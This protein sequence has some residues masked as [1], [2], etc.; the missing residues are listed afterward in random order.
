MESRQ[1]VERW[2]EL[3][4]AADAEGIS[5]LY[6]EDAVNDQV[7]FDKPVVGRQA[8][9][10][11]F[12][13]EFLR[14]PMV[15]RKENLLESGDWVVLEWSDPVGLRGCGFFK[16][17]NGKIVLQRGYF[18]QLTFFKHQNIPIPVTYLEI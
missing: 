5:Q 11:M 4:N 17:K 2:V 15:C 13:A 18:D 6:A 3:F 16:I 10:E 9:R 1:I 8:I 12:Q 7:V 14:A